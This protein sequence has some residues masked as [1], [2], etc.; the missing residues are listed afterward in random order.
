MSPEKQETS[1]NS[2][3]TSPE[4]AAEMLR[5]MGI[6]DK[7]WKE[8]AASGLQNHINRALI[9]IALGSEPRDVNEVIDELFPNDPHGPQRKES[10]FDQLS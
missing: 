9:H 10:I 5:S 3:L 2:T 1:D 6:E 7:Y 4:K 8:I